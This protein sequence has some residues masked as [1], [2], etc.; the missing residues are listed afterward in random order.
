MFCAAPLSVLYLT[1]VDGVWSNWSG[2]SACSKSCGNGTSSRSR[3]CQYLPAGAPQG[4][5][6]PGQSSESIPCN[7]TECPRKFLFRHEKST[8][9]AEIS[10]THRNY[11]VCDRSVSV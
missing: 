3:T 11:Q 5:A 8:I 7:T 4:K 10:R 2:F 9:D 1:S 6:C